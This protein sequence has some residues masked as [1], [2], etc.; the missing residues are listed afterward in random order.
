M[1]RSFNRRE[2]ANIR[3]QLRESAT[4]LFRTKGV[5]KTTID[6]LARAAGI[7]KGSFYK[8]YDSKELLFFE[9]LEDKNV[10]MRAPMLEEFT[11]GRHNARAVF[12]RRLRK[13][14][15]QTYE[16]PLIHLMGSESEFHALL[17][18]V[19]PERIRN[20]ERADQVFLEKMIARWG[21]PHALPDR[22]VVAARLSA[23]LLIC[24][25]RDFIGK[26]LFPYAFDAA[27][28]SIVACFFDRAGANQTR[29]RK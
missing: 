3:E 1:P 26:R 15:V 25:R 27:V 11:G 8:F 24:L 22:D 17:R 10:S 28:E 2:S 20:H 5:A 23:A 6:E 21:E 19:P 18:R 7:A 4:R 16:E 29:A 12:E 9:I 14:L 13:L